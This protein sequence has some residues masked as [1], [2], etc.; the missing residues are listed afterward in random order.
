[1]ILLRPL[2]RFKKWVGRHYWHLYSKDTFLR[3][4]PPQPQVLDVGCGNNSPKLIK[5]WR[6]DCYYVGLDVGDYNQDVTPD[7]IAD[8]YILSSPEGFAPAIEAMHE[9][10]NAVIS[11]HNIEHC[12]DPDRTLKAMLNALKI[13]GRLYLS[14]PSEASVRFPS[15]VGTLNFYDDPTHRHVLNFK[16]TRET[17]EHAGFR[18]DVAIRRYRPLSHA[19]PGLLKEPLYAIQ[20]RVSYQT[21]ALYGFE[22]INW[23]TRIA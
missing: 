13:G 12:D 8:K 20:K 18:I 2:E 22:S 14:F 11:S 1:M 15:R 17:I 4:L 3:S 9:N 16:Q 7:S 19:I 6:P 5:T 10:F 21:W 23:A